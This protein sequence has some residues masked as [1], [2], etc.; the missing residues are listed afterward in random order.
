MGQPA[1]FSVVPRPAWLTFPRARP[2]QAGHPTNLAGLA[3][4]RGWV[5]LQGFRQYLFPN[6]FHTFHSESAYPERE[7]DLTR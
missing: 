2:N 4:R 1:R 7:R 3:G 6:L 5:N